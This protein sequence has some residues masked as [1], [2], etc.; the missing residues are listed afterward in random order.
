MLIE[1]YVLFITLVSIYKIC[2]I[3]FGK[4]LQDMYTTY[5]VLSV[6]W[7]NET[8]CSMTTSSLDIGQP[9]LSLRR[10]PCSWR[11]GGRWLRIAG[12][13]AQEHIQFVHHPAA[14]LVG[15]LPIGPAV[16][17][18]PSCSKGVG[19]VGG[20]SPG[21]FWGSGMYLQWKHNIL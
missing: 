11:G 19:H 18:P 10:V 21:E 12:L 3:A 1:S 9:R 7:P 17:V 15:T 8:K 2:T 4:H 14:G 20:E 16:I 13:L 5:T 6:T